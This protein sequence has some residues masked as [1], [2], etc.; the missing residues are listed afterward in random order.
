MVSEEVYEAVVAELDEIRGEWRKA[1]RRAALAEERVQHLEAEMAELKK[2]LEIRK[3][4][5]KA[6]RDARKELESKVVDPQ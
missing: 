3:N 6:C 4:E 5:L 1:S 2:E